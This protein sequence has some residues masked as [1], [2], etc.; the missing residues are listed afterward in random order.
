MKL[1]A[2]RKSEQN[3]AAV[4]PWTIVHFAAGLALGLMDVRFKHALAASVAYELAEQ[5]FQRYEWGQEF[6]E[7]SGPE[8]VPN[9]VLDS[10][11]YAAGHRLGRMWNEQKNGSPER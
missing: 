5:V 1:I 3:E 4:D 11:T 6:F 8:T 9:A 10:V 2:S 7:T